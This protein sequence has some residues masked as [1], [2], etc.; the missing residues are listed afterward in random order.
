M[1]DFFSRLGKPVGLDGRDDGHV[2]EK[3]PEKYTE[4]ERGVAEEDIIVHVGLEVL[5]RARVGGYA[6]GQWQP[7]VDPSARVWRYSSRTMEDSGVVVGNGTSLGRSVR[8]VS[9]TVQ[10]KVNRRNKRKEQ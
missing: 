5:H 9:S 8:G 7:E 1:I 4:N 3:D 6:V 10:I 2:H